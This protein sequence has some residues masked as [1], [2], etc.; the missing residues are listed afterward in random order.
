MAI[1]VNENIEEVRNSKGEL[2]AT[3]EYIRPPRPT[4]IPLVFI[5]NDT[6]DLQMFRVCKNGKP[7]AFPLVHPHTR[8]TVPIKRF[9]NVR[10]ND[11]ITVIEHLDEYVFDGTEFD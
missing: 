5:W 8:K 10:E 2:R 11:V 1:L 9:M 3:Y 4:L 7:I 6:D